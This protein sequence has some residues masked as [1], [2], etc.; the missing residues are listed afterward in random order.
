MLSV[1]SY[2]AF[3]SMNICEYASQQCD[4]LIMFQSGFDASKEFVRGDDI[5]DIWFDS[6]SSW[7]AVLKGSIINITFVRLLML[8]TYVTY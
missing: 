5:L 1:N 4:H 3:E 7:A 6:G 8:E 2:L